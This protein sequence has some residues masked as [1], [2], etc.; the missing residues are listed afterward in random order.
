MN[1]ATLHGVAPEG[2]TSS[3]LR[4][5]VIPADLVG[6]LEAFCHA[7]TA[8]QRCVIV[9]QI[10]GWAREKSDN[11]RPG[12][13]LLTEALES[14]PELRRAVQESLATMVSEVQSLSLFAE[15]GLPSVHSFPSC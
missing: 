8:R 2:Q 9:A 3:S 7:A 1:D 5:M 4:P 10:A 14:Q 11:F 15:A 13:T 6:L 12:L